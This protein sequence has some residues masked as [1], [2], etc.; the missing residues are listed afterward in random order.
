MNIVERLKLGWR[1]L[2]FSRF[3]KATE[4]L[5]SL[6]KMSPQLHK[7]KID[8]LQNIKPQQLPDESLYKRCKNK[9]LIATHILDSDDRW[10]DSE[11]QKLVAAICDQD[12]LRAVLPRWL[13]DNL[14]WMVEKAVRKVYAELHR[15][16]LDLIRDQLRLEAKITA[17]NEKRSSRAVLMQ[18][19]N[20]SYGSEPTAGV[21]L[22]NISVACGSG[23]SK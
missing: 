19:I 18:E 16:E 21:T 5:G 8:G 23:W 10:T 1:I 22:E 3:S 15:T 2:L 9:F 11:K 6:G 12:E 14:K 20:Q 13:V 4:L 7:V 17:D